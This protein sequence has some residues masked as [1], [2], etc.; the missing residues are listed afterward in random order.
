MEFVKYR[1]PTKQFEENLKIAPLLDL[2]LTEGYGMTVE[3]LIETKKE[4]LR[5]IGTLSPIDTKNIQ[6]EIDKIISIFNDGTEH[7]MKKVIYPKG[8]EV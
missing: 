3:E 7:W 5:R 8:F 4:I 1:N 6:S 2:A